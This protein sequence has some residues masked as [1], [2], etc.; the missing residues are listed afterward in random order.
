[1]A[2]PVWLP[3]ALKAGSMVSS[4]IGSYLEG[5]NQRDYQKRVLKLQQEAQVKQQ[6]ME[7]QFILLVMIQHF[8]WIN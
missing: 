1:M 2:I 6:L 7:A 3:F 8:P 5:R 4:G